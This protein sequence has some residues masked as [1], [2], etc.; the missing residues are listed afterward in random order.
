MHQ[1][2]KVAYGGGRHVDMRCHNDICELDKHCRCIPPMHL[3]RQPNKEYECDPVPSKQSPP[4]GP[5]LMMDCFT[6]PNNIHPDATLIWKQLPKR[7]CGELV[8]RSFELVDGWGIY[9]EEGWDWFK[10]WCVLGI[11]FFPPSLLFGILWAILKKDIQG[12]FGV[13][14]WWMTGATILVGVVGTC[15]WTF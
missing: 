7:T 13:A 8:S 3:V 14:S 1:A 10:I 5:R 9:Y 11:G 6:D 15:T 12:A 2:I 4:V